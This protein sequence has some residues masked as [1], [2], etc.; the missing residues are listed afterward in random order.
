[1]VYLF[2]FVVVIPLNMF[3]IKIQYNTLQYKYNTQYNKNKKGTKIINKQK[4]NPNS[5]N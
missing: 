1:M 3:K 4:G 5:I 2:S